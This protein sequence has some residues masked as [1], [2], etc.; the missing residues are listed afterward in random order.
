MINKIYL[1]SLN[2][3]KMI[4]WDTMVQ[5]LESS[6]Q[7]GVVYIENDLPTKEQVIQMVLPILKSKLKNYLLSDII[8][9]IET[10]LDQEI[11][12]YI[13]NSLDELVNTSVNSCIDQISKYVVEK[14]SL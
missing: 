12:R 10:Q 3:F 2:Q 8:P 6:L 5:Y 9:E 4:Q 7:E 1:K 11:D 14:L 13:P